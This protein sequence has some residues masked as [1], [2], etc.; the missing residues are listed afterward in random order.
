MKFGSLFIDDLHRDVA[1]YHLDFLAYCSRVG[2]RNVLDYFPEG[3]R[4]DLK[5]QSFEL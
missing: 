5:F 3:N 2:L 1:N 4:K